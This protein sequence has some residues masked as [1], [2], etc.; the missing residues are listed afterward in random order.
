MQLWRVHN[1][2]LPVFGLVPSPIGYTLLASREAAEPLRAA[3]AARVYPPS[4]E[5]ALPV[6]HHP[7]EILEA[8]RA[9]ETGLAVLRSSTQAQSF[10]ERL[11]AARLGGPRPVTITVRGFAL[12]TV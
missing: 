4:Y 12:L 2:A 5:P 11:A 1:I 8:A 6:G 3:A 7:A 10:V 9:G